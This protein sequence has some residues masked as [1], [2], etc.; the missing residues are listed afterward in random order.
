MRSLHAR[1]RLLCEDVEQNELPLNG[2]LSIGKIYYV[3]EYIATILLINVNISESC[4]RWS[5]PRRVTYE[6][7]KLKLKV[8]DYMFK[9]E[10]TKVQ[11]TLV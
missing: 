3:N 9:D 5:T 8:C 4:H 1:F 10:D 6:H 11:L 2:Q 7:P